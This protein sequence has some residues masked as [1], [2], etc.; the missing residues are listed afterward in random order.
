MNECKRDEFSDEPI[1]DHISL[2]QALVLQ[3]DG[4]GDHVFIAVVG[5]VAEFP[6]WVRCVPSGRAV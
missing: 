3:R 2:I 1:N 5:R 4:D 6:F